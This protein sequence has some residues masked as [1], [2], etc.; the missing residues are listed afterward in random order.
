MLSVLKAKVRAHPT[1]TATVLAI[2]GWYGG[3][4]L[5]DVLPSGSSWRLVLFAVF[6]VMIG[7]T[8]RVLHDVTLYFLK[9]SLALSEKREQ[10]HRAREQSRAEGALVQEALDRPL[11]EIQARYPAMSNY[12]ARQSSPHDSFEQAAAVIAVAARI[13]AMEDAARPPAEQ[14]PVARQR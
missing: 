12:L 9:A 1:G 13:A 3:N 10:E 11:P 5:N 4:W 7:A 8:I 14:T 6:T 2:A